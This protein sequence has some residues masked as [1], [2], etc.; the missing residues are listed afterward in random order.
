MH[1]TAARDI[2]VKPT[3]IGG[4]YVAH[5]ERA[6]SEVLHRELVATFHKSLEQRAHKMYTT[7]D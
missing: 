5:V 1:V 3:A 6:Q 2:D 7:E 4:M